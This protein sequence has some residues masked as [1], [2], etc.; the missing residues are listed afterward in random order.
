MVNRKIESSAD[1]L[2][3]EVGE[4]LKN[5]RCDREASTKMLHQHIQEDNLNLRENTSN[6]LK[7]LANARLENSRNQ[8]GSLKAETVQR[9]QD[10][11]NYLGNLKQKR[12][13]MR[14]NAHHVHETLCKEVVA[15]SPLPLP[16]VEEQPKEEPIQLAELVYYLLTNDSDRIR[17][18]D[19]TEYFGSDR[20]EK[21]WDDLLIMAE[22][23]RPG[24]KKELARQ[25]RRSL[26]TKAK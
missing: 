16:I 4:L 8:S 1:E 24:S 20:V 5:Y 15:T 14:T 6:Y 26:N 12:L 10:I 9:K 11:A 19:L 23:L 7:D 18:A 17:L 25:H 22:E 13:N 3:A 2:K 21:S